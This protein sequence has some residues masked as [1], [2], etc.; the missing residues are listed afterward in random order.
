MPKWK[1][2]ILVGA[3]SGS[4]STI[5]IAQNSSPGNVGRPAHDTLLFLARLQE[6]SLR[7]N[8]G[9]YASLFNMAGDWNGPHG[10]NASGTA[11][12]KSAIAKFFIDFGA[13]HELATVTTQFAPDLVMADVYQSAD[14]TNLQKKLP[15]SDEGQLSLRAD[16]RT[17]LILF[18]SRSGEWQIFDAHVAD[19]R[20][21]KRN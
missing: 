8:A 19:L 17:T 15:L 3:I 13:L 2:V 20:A 18:K 4:L 16:V 14:A 9:E 6:A 1:S 12:V 10:E 7:Q 21:T 5:C 11:R